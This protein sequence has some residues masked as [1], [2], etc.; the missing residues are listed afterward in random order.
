MSLFSCNH[1]STITLTTLTLEQTRFK[2]VH[3]IEKITFAT[4]NREPNYIP[5]N[6]N[7]KTKVNKNNFFKRNTYYQN[8]SLT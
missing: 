5:Q 6:Y 2:N 3:G 8:A 4:T 1:S 7:T